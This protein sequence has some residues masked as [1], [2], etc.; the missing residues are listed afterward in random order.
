MSSPAL[1]IAKPQVVRTQK[2]AKFEVKDG[3]ATW[4]LTKPF[5]RKFVAFSEDGV[6]E[7]KSGSQI[8][9]LEAAKG[10]ALDFIAKATEAVEEELKL[11]I[12]EIR[13]AYKFDDSKKTVSIIPDFGYNESKGELVLFLNKG[14][15]KCFIK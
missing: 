8:L 15:T 7:T 3:K 4:T 12:A 2:K 5:T 11:H 14:R 6:R 13:A 10:T 1:V 9:V